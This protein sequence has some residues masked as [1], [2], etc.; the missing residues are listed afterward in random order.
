VLTYVSKQEALGGKGVTVRPVQAKLHSEPGP[1]RGV[2]LDEAGPC[3]APIPSQSLPIS[4]VFVPMPAYP[5]I[6][7]WLFTIWYLSTSANATTKKALSALATGL[8]KV[9]M[10]ASQNE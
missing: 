1:H 4:L 6:V 2:V 10:F 8:S 5:I 3:R 9:F 7:G